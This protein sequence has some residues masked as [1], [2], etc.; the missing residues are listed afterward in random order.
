MCAPF[1][2]LLSY[3]K[4]VGDSS[5][6]DWLKEREGQAAWLITD[7]EEV[8]PAVCIDTHADLSTGTN[9]LP[10]QSLD[11]FTSEYQSMTKT[12]THKNEDN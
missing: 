7:S 6:V 9:V 12:Y 1:L 10:G 8:R 3:Q 2:N 5:L 4:R 11:L